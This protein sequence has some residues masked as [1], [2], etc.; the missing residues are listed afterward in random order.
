MQDGWGGQHVKQDTSWDVGGALSEPA[1]PL[2][3]PKADSMQWQ[4]PATAR[5]DGTDL[6][7]STLSGQQQNKCIRRT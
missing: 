2:L 4:A 6:W 7:K 3:P 1:T 5:N